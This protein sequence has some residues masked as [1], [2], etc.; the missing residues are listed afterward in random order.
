VG[1]VFVEAVAKI[2]FFA[3]FALPEKDDHFLDKLKILIIE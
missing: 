2:Y 3:H 1:I